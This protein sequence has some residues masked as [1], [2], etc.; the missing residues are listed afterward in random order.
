M[1]KNVTP[2]TDEQKMRRRVARAFA[3]KLWR[4]EFKAANP[5]APKSDVNAAWKAARRSRTRAGL[6][7]IRRLEKEGFKI[8]GPA[9]KTASKAASDK[10]APSAGVAAA[11]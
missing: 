5:E 10:A 11:V 9:K 3:R 7:V 1:G 8:S 2:L 4:A 6:G